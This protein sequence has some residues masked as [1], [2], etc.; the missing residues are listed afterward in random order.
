MFIFQTKIWFREITA[1]AL[2]PH[3]IVG[4]KPFPFGVGPREGWGVKFYTKKFVKI[5]HKIPLELRNRFGSNMGLKNGSIPTQDN[6]VSDVY[7]VPRKY[8]GL[9]SEITDLLGRLGVV[10][11]VIQNLSFVS[12]GIMLPSSV[13]FLKQW[14]LYA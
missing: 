14:L 11:E 2:L 4:I 5:W 10:S 6:S 9:F 7:Y 13:T 8:L 1:L 12:N 3:A